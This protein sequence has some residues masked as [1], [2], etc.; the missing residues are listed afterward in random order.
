MPVQFQ[1][2]LLRRFFRQSAVVQEVIGQAE[3]HALV[4][5]DNI[6]EVWDFTLLCQSGIF[7]ESDCR[8]SLNAHCHSRSQ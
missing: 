2:N 3:Y 8:A 1:K 6:G 5:P 4:L 7:L